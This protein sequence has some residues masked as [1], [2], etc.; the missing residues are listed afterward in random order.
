MDVRDR[1][2]EMRLVPADQLIANPSNWRRH[3]QAQQRALSAVLDEVGFAGAVIARED[4][5]GHL[6][7][8]DGHARA[9]M[10][11]KATVP[12]LVTDLTEAEADLVLA[13]YDPIGAM[14]QKD[15]EAFATLAAR[16]NTGNETLLALLGRT[17]DGE[18]DPDDVPDVLTEPKSKLGEVYE[19]G[20]H[21]V[22]CGDATS[23]ADVE[24][25]LG[26]ARPN[27]V[28]TSPPYNQRLD[29]FKP[30]GMHRET[31]AWVRRMAAAYP[32]SL[33]EDEYQTAQI[34]LCDLMHEV[35]ADGASMFYNH[36]HRYRDRMV[37]AP[38]EW[39]SKTRWN[40]RQEIIWDRAKSPTHNARMFMPVDERIYWLTKGKFRFND[41]TEIK[42]LGTIWRMNPRAESGVTAPYPIEL[43]ER[44][45]LASTGA[46]DAALDPF[47]G[48]GTTLI[49]CEQTGRICYGMEIEPKYVDVIRQRYADFVGDPSLAPDG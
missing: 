48:S 29:Q 23:A 1:V 13:T 14:A 49:A 33:P 17:K 21:R 27:A 36:K 5:D 19:L 10:V 39:L 34:A 31:P 42:S 11:G 6:I 35:T 43:P 37:V 26:D 40:W 25:L 28:V 7:I 4:D 22:M 20:P 18:T 38:M 8:I 12:V 9:E 24:A 45:I 47:L 15:H 41:S 2:K 30:S 44:C 32:D 3:P 46:G 16:I